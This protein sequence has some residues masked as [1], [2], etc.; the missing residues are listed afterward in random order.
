LEDV[1]PSVY[2]HLVELEEARELAEAPSHEGHLI[3]LRENQN[4]CLEPQSISKHP[5]HEEQVQNEPTQ[6]PP[7]EGKVGL[8]RSSR[9]SRLAIPSD[10]VVYFQSLILMLGLTIIQ[11]RFHKP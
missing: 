9:I 5:T 8:R 6:P 7:N 10:Y 11:N 3:V 1:E 2:P 4:D